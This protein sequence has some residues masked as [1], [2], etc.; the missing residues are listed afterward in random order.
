MYDFKRGK[1]LIYR[2]PYYINDNKRQLYW[3]SASLAEFVKMK[4]GRNFMYK[5][6]NNKTFLF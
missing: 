5:L 2:Y 1:K 3:N 4:R 6:Y